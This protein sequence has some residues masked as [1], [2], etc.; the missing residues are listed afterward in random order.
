MGLFDAF[1][2]RTE[3]K[4]EILN[5]LYTALEQANFG[6]QNMQVVNEQGNATVS[7]SV[8][9]GSILEKVNDFLAAQ[10]GVSTVSNNIEIAD[11]SAQG[12]KC[13]VVT[14][15]SNLNVRAGASTTDDIV[16]R[17]ANDS[18]VLLVRRYNSTWHQVRGK[19]IKGNEVEGYCHTD[20]LNAL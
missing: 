15:G 17:Y 5:P 11:I 6:I 2:K 18:E 8:D 3:A 20:Y 19:G 13:K 16:G 1:K 4:T 14:K 9:D 10:A 7:G 12:N